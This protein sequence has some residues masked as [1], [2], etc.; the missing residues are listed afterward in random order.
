M[1]QSQLAR[2]V[3]AFH[4]TDHDDVVQGEDVAEAEGYVEESRVEI[5][6]QVAVQ[7]DLEWSSAGLRAEA[8][9]FTSA[10]SDR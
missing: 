6:L 4:I 5:R 2:H 8:S 1:L 3:S 9:V 7:C 10:V